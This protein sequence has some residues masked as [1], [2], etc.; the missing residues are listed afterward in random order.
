MS[1][2]WVQRIT[3]AAIESHNFEEPDLYEKTEIQIRP[4]A[5]LVPKKD[6]LRAYQLDRRP[7]LVGLWVEFKE[8]H[9]R[10]GE[11]SKWLDMFKAKLR[12]AMGDRTEVWIGDELVGSYAPD[13]NF[14][15]KKFAEENPHIAQQYVRQVTEEKFDV[16]AFKKD[17]PALFE[18][19]R[20]RSMRLK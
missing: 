11:D 6:P 3:K 2:P 8:R 19:N 7:D 17:H 5:P 9:K 18:A 14:P 16:E 20:A 1:D 10:C 4:A 13:G 15:Y 12:E